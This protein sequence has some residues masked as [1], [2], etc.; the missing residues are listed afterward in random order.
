MASGTRTIAYH[1]F[2]VTF[3]MNSQARPS[4]EYLG[5]QPSL[6]AARLMRASLRLRINDDVARIRCILWAP[7]GD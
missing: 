4:T 7:D 1:R 6:V 3:G 5:D 2:A